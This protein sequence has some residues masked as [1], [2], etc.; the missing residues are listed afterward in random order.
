[1]PVSF[2]LPN[3]KGLKLQ[4]DSSQP[5]LMGLERFQIVILICICLMTKAIECFFI[6]LLTILICS[7]VH[8][9]IFKP[10]SF[11]FIV[12]LNLIVYRNF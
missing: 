8:I 11:Y 6:H 5:I 7:F 10:V 2:F 3:P 12:C 9:H 4:F 1:M